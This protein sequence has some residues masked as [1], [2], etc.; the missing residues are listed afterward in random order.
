MNEEPIWPE[1]PRWKVLQRLKQYAP[2]LS[3]ACR[4]DGSGFDW[5]DSHL[6]GRVSQ[7]VAILVGYERKREHWH[8]SGWENIKIIDNRTPS[9]RLVQRINNLVK[10][11]IEARQRL[12]SE[13]LLEKAA[14]TPDNLET[15]MLLRNFLQQEGKFARAVKEHE[16]HLWHRW[17]SWPLLQWICDM[18]HPDAKK[19]ILPFVD[20]HESAE[21]CD[22]RNDWRRYKNRERQKRR[23]QRKNS[24]P[25]KRDKAQS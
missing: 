8:R 17:K 18:E 2:R 5:P 16:N 10:R 6:L 12:C 25:K 21:P 15:Q 7:C 1:T 23:R 20:A 3:K 13:S 14:R 19:L 4:D 24:L 9:L 11:A 22:H